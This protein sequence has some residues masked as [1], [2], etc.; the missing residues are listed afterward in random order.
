MNVVHGDGI[1]RARTNGGDAELAYEIRGK[2]MAITHTYVPD[3]ERGKGIAEELTSAAFEFA[4]TNKLKVSP[5]CSYARHFVD[6]H[7][8]VSD[9]VAK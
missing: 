5:E 3:G 9:L 2:V 4:R 7:H 8:E 6:I 1:F